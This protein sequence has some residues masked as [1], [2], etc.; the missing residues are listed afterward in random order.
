MSVVFQRRG[1]LNR[2]FVL[3]G[4]SSP[5]ASQ[6]LTFQ[7]SPRVESEKGRQ[8]KGGKKGT[9]LPGYY[10]VKTLLLLLFRFVFSYLLPYERRTLNSL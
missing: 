10:K 9:L 7:T 1:K 3:R 5:G 4:Q 8:F 6:V 2:R